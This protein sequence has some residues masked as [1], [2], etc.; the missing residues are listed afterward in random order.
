M[1]SANANL[2]VVGTD[3]DSGLATPSGFHENTSLQS[4]VSPVSAEEFRAQHWEQKPL[5][6]HRQ[7][8]DYYGDLFTLQDFDSSVRRSNGYVKTAEATTK[9]TARHHGV[10]PTA[11]EHVLTDMRDGATLILDSVHQFNTKLGQ[12]CRMLG[13]DTGFYYQT[14]IYLTPANG[15]GF[16]PHWDNHD[17]FIMQVVG[18]KHWKV[19]KTRRTLPLKDANI[20]DEGRE[21]RGEVY[22]FTLEQGD[23]VYIPRGF[24]HAAECGAES[25]MHI[26]LGIHP[27][28]W[29]E[30]LHAAIKAAVARDDNLRLSLPIGYHKGGSAGIVSRIEEVLRNVTDTAFLTQVLDQYRDEIVQKAP[31][32]IEGQ[33]ASFYQPRS[34]SLDDRMGARAGLYYTIRRHAD[35]VTLNVGTR[36]ITFPDFFSEALTFA[37]EKPSF[38]IRELPGNLEDEERLVFIERLIQEALVVRV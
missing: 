38:A 32:D 22:E 8:P 12:M 29:D 13:Q 2:T 17:V 33:I 6:L 23:T 20:E 15:K 16:A 5:I 11:L 25:S 24:V 31:L 18:R 4:L 36:T 21:L 3:R 30:L 14:N 35:S 10:S 28:T 9:K 26:T 37:L 1:Q 27:Y 7:R 19:E 34:L